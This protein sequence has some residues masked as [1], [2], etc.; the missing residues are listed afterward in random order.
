MPPL[1]VGP[2]SPLKNLHFCFGGHSKHYL[3]MCMWVGW[4]GGG[5]TAP[6]GRK[7]RVPGIGILEQTPPGYFH[8]PPSDVATT[9][10]WHVVPECTPTEGGRAW[11]SASYRRWK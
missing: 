7:W 5:G 9:T 1:P 2:S 4:G 6:R 11:L 8:F 10:I 3:L